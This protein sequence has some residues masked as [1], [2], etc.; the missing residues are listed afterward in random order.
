VQAPVLADVDG[1]FPRHHSLTTPEGQL[2]LPAVPAQR[3][4]SNPAQHTG[5]EWKPLGPKTAT[6]LPVKMHRFAAQVLDLDL[7]QPSGLPALVRVKG[8]GASRVEVC[9]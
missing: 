4:I 5:D 7:D 1:R 2:P 6:H 9:W 8:P 3:A